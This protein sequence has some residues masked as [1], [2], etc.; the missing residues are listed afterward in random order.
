MSN[1][2]T[3]FKKEIFKLFDSAS[4]WFLLI[5]SLLLNFF[6]VSH[7]MG[8]KFDKERADSMYGA[9]EETDF[10]SSNIYETTKKLSPETVIEEPDEKDFWSLDAWRKRDNAI[11]SKEAAI[12]YY[13]G[14]IGEYENFYNELDMMAVEEEKL[15]EIGYKVS[16]S[17]KKFLDNQYLELQRRVKE[18]RASGEG[19]DIF[20]LGNYINFHSKLYIKILRIAVL[21]MLLIMMVSVSYLMDYERNNRTSDVI[22]SSCFG[23]KI[24]YIKAAA[25]T[26]VGFLFS[27]VIMACTLL[28]FFSRIPMKG[29]WNTSVSSIFIAEDREL[30]YP[31][32][33]WKSMTVAGYLV[34]TVA[35]IML[36]VVIVGMFSAAVWMFMKNGWYTFT[37]ML[38]IAAVLYFIPQIYRIKNFFSTIFLLNPV[39]LWS[40]IGWWFM[41]DEL[42]LCFRGNE[43]VSI[44]LFAVTSAILLVLSV[45]SYWKSSLDT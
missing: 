15:Q 41:E 14:F 45:V 11:R 25:G 34:A 12:E 20:Y 22:I 10:N 23:R 16:D 5:V 36:F 42:P 40:R 3:I 6:L 13:Y 33:T 21:E 32:I 27:A 7:Y 28:V 2:M 43:A 8:S 18:I 1:R 31:F 37:I 26:C 39:K 24:A 38:G 44:A 29:L 4:L 30:F 35:L 9:I 17:Y 19:N